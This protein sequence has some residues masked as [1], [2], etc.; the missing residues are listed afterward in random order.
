VEPDFEKQF[1]QAMQIPH[2]VDEFPH[3]EGVVPAEV[4]R[5]K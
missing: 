1:M 2:M 5:Q 3:L 4:L